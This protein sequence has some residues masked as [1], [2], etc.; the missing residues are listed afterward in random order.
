[1]LPDSVRL[2]RPMPSIRRIA[3]VNHQRAAGCREM[4]MRRVLLVMAML[5]LAI[6]AYAQRMGGGKQAGASK[7]DQAQAKEEQEKKRAVEEGYKDALK[8]IPDK[9]APAD[10]WK[11]VR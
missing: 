6:P 1:M 5:L 2:A 4:P 11:T 8:R 3:S 7:S 10:P 9:A